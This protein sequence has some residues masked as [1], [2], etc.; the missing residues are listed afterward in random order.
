MTDAVAAVGLRQG[1]AEDVR[2]N[3]HEL[4]WLAVVPGN[5]RARRF[6]RRNGWSD[7]G[8]FTHHASGPDGPVLVPAHRYVKDV[9]RP[10]S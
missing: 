7:E 1:R 4:A 3:R 10:D 5:A 2:A 6:Y 8:L 9:A